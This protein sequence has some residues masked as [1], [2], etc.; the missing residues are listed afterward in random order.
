[1][2]FY[3]GITEVDMNVHVTFVQSK[4]FNNAFECEYNMFVHDIGYVPEFPHYYRV[5]YVCLSVSVTICLC[6]H[7][8]CLCV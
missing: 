2:N 8:L 3:Y 5:L 1:M 7:C 6:V 4:V